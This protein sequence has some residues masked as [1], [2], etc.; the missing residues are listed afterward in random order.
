MVALALSVRVRIAPLKTPL[1]SRVK[2]PIC[3]MIRVLSCREAAPC[4]LDSGTSPAGQGGR[5]LCRAEAVAEDDKTRAFL[6]RQAR[7]KRPGEK[8]RR[9]N[10]GAP[11]GRPQAPASGGR[12]GRDAHGKGR[13]PAPRAE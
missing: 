8:L 2:V 7:V 10:V 11:D 4:G 1:S 13:V 5:R 12:P 9:R 6:S 3:A